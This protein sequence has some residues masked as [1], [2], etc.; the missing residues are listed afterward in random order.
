MSDYDHKEQQRQY[1]E[2]IRLIEAQNRQR[3]D[4]LK[5][6]FVLLK[7]QLDSQ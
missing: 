2:T 7:N 3:S 1:D 5:K 4:E 6:Q